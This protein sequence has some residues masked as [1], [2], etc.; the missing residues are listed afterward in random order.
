MLKG[1]ELYERYRALT[2]E[3]REKFKVFLDERG[4]GDFNDLFYEFLQLKNR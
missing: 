3:E 4:K 1:K 2:P